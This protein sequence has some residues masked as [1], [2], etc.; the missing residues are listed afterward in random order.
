MI[1]DDTHG[2]AVLHK[3]GTVAVPIKLLRSYTAPL[4]RVRVFHRD[5][6]GPPD[7]RELLEYAAD[8]KLKPALRAVAVEHFDWKVRASQ[9]V[10][11]YESIL[12]LSRR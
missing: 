4:C 7:A 11:A 10:A 5:R 9:M 1:V 12:A 6:P 3:G 8:P 2:L